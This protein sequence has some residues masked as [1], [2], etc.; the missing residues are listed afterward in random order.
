[1]NHN[2]PPKFAAKLLLSISKFVSPNK[3]QS[4]AA[5][6]DRELVKRSTTTKKRDPLGANRPGQRDWKSDQLSNQIV[7]A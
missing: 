6:N 2:N 3:L 7:P 1:M 5:E 4:A